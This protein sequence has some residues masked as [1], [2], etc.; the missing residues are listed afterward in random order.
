[1]LV[2]RRKSVSHVILTWTYDKVEN[3]RNSIFCFLFKSGQIQHNVDWHLKNSLVFWKPGKAQELLRFK[4][5]K[6]V[7]MSIVDS[8]FNHVQRFYHTWTRSTKLHCFLTIQLI[9]YLNANLCS[10][11]ST[12]HI[13]ICVQTFEFFAVAVKYQRI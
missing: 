12:I 4:S 8:M 11:H 1:M 7:F 10:S 5:Q 2:W 13:D 9:S 3:I 6:F